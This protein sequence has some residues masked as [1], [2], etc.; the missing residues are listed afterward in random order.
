VKLS[1]FPHRTKITFSLFIILLS[2]CGSDNKSQTPDNRPAS[3][4]H[5]WNEVVLQSIRKDRVRPPVQARNLFHISA[6]MYDAWAIY[7]PRQNSRINN[8][9][10]RP[11]TYLLGKTLNGFTC[12]LSVSI[13]ANDAQPAREEAISYASY[14]LIKHR[15]Q[16][17]P[18]YVQTMVMAD[19]LMTDLGY[20][21]NNTSTDVTSKSPAALGNYIAQCYINY[22]LQDGSNE[23]GS[24]A[25]QHYQPVNPPLAPFLPGNST[26][27]D[28]DRWQP[29]ALDVF[30][31]QGGNVIVGGSP[32]FM[33][34]E[35]GKTLPFALTAVDM[36]R[37][38]RNN[39]EYPVYLD[40]G[41][42]PSIGDENPI[43]YQWSFALVAKW[44]SHLDPTDGVMIDISPASLGD[45]AD[46][47]LTFGDHRFFYD[48]REGGASEQGHT[49]N[50]KTGQAYTPQIVPRGDY[51]RVL[52]EFW[53]DGP[54][55]ETPPGHWFALFNGISEDDRL[56]KRFRGQGKDLGSLEWDEKG[57]FTLGGA[58]HDAAI[59][60]WGVKGWYDYARPIAAIRAMA[61]LGQSTNPDALSYHPQGIPLDPGFIELVNFG[62]ILSGQGNVNVGKIKVRAWRGPTAIQTPA[63][64][65]AGVGWI[66]AENWFPYQRPSFVT[67]PFGGYVSGHSTFSRAAAEVLTAFTGDEYFPGGLGEFPVRQNEYLVFE[68]GPSV[69]LTL[70]WAT[71]RDAANQCSLSRI[72]GGIHPPMD[73]IP[74]RL[75]GEEIGVRAVEVAEVFFNGD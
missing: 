60:A 12:P 73:D 74:G 24:H 50:P 41:A 65:T 66:L 53:A 58:M 3:V 10:K 61:D 54:N 57:Y 16:Q 40:P 38:E 1:Y 45:S 29:I 7:S 63:T 5:Q 71:Y 6:A 22:G 48:D 19:Q 18:G 62:D 51:T 37:Y 36:I 56:I 15:Y 14:R 21:I 67:P 23:S 52:A 31:D 33:G 39:N 72:W 25:N 70:Q 64:D 75:M 9:D 42:P 46:L 28:K 68:E 26:V 59:A 34:A 30:V 47:P 35:W 32:S 17:S 43:N 4:A 55:S 44:S 2:A 8:S 27:V 69:D 11:R 20:D 49:L 13:N